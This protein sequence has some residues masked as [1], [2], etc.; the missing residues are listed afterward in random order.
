MLIRKHLLFYLGCALIIGGALALAWY[1]YIQVDMFRTKR[2]AE[3][4]HR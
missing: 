4:A 2:A 1:A 3:S